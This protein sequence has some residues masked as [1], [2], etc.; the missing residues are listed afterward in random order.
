MLKF[1]GL[2]IVLLLGGC[3]FYV[4]GPVP[5]SLS[6]R[7]EPPHA[8][9][10]S[11]E[12][13]SGE[14]YFEKML[15]DETGTY[16][17]FRLRLSL[18]EPI[19]AQYF[20]SKTKTKNGLI[21]VLPLYG[22]HELP[23]ELLVWYLTVFNYRADFNVL[24]IQERINDGLLDAFIDDP[25]NLDAFAAIKTEEE[26]VATARESVTRTRKAV[27]GIRHFLDWAEKEP[28]VDVKRIGIVGLSTSSLLISVAMAIEPRISAGV[29]AFGGGYLN[30]IF[31]YAEEPRLTKVRTTVLKNTGKTVEEFSS[32]LKSL[33]W[34]IEPISYAWALN[35]ARILYIDAARDEFFPQKGRD[36]LWNAL[37][38][39]HRITYRYR[40]RQAFLSLTPLGLN[41][42]NYKI[43]E[44]FRK[45]L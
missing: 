29:I 33:F 2:L 22:K 31:A 38:R 6:P 15:T 28:S 17:I 11:Y 7:S 27:V 5:D 25:F 30:E 42:T 41:H 43:A 8:L 35:P 44:F 10:F 9:L 32:L 39:P 19:E 3:A 45:N 18:P 1:I 12:K 34:E 14:K 36:A 40:H 4:S 20:Q 24:Y 23:A 37:G 16:K 21:I 26:L 13:V